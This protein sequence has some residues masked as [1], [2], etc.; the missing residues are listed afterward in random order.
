MN[1]YDEII[2]SKNFNKTI[3]IKIIKCYFM[4]SC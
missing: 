4:C 1:I 3:A 2:C